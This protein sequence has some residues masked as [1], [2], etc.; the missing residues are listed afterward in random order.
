MEAL[1]WL[2]NYNLEAFLRFAAAEAGY[3]LD[4]DELAV[5]M[6]EIRQADAE[7]ERWAKVDFPGSS[8]ILM[9][10]APDLGT[11]VIHLRCQ[12][13]TRS[14]ARLQAIVDFLSVNNAQPRG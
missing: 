12:A 5:Y 14:I 6:H 13:S 3:D 4:T 8:R 7:H 10:L 11:D 9:E 2:W 1:N